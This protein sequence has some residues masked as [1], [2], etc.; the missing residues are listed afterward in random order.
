MSV[1]EISGCGPVDFLGAPQLLP[2]EKAGEY[3]ALQ[4]A[5]SDALQPN[6][7]FERIWVVELASQVW[8]TA[9]YRKMMAFLVCT[10][11]RMALE[12]VLTPI[13]PKHQFELESRAVQLSAECA[14]KDKAAIEEVQQHLKAA[15]LTWDV[16]V[17]E[18]M[19]IRMSDYQRLNQMLAKTEARRNSTLKAIE[20]HRTG[21]GEQLR[22]IA[23]QF[24]TTKVHEVPDQASARKLA[25]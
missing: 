11:E 3:Q 20:R 16:V 17:A 2:S 12:R 22:A 4:G 10:T 19:A 13:V 21:L 18:A 5:M 8:E 9:R 23:D 14:R 7:V 6:D 24:E 15:G 25:A 1:R